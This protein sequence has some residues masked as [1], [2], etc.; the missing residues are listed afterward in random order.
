MDQY[1]KVSHLALDN[2]RNFSRVTTRDA[3]NQ[4]LFRQR[5]E[6]A[7]HQH[8]REQLRRYPPGTPVILE[9]TFGGG[10]WPTNRPRPRADSCKRWPLADDRGDEHGAPPIG[11]HVGHAGRRT[12]KWAFIEPD[13]IIR[14]VGLLARRQREWIA[15]PTESDESSVPVDRNDQNRHRVSRR[16]PR[17]KVRI[18]R[19]GAAGR[20]KT[21]GTVFDAA[22]PYSH[23]R[24]DRVVSQRCPIRRKG[25]A[26]MPAEIVSTRENPA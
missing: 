22:L 13:E 8:L 14:R 20:S 2:H 19:I 25:N 16:E 18:D 3:D 9:A 17:M 11:R 7:D 4:L 24:G 10:G 23:R 26:A 15:G 6:H 1:A 12:L 5:L 21:G